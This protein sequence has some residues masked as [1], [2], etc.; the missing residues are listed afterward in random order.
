MNFGQYPCPKLVFF[1]WIDFDLC[2]EHHSNP[3]EFD[4]Y[5]GNQSSTVSQN[6]S[7]NEMFDKFGPT[8]EIDSRANASDSMQQKSLQM[9]VQ[10]AVTNAL[11]LQN[12]DSTAGTVIFLFHWVRFILKML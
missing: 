5:V 11:N 1:S 7:P 10:A 4:G 3:H 9:T 6:K 8:I 2:I 12:A